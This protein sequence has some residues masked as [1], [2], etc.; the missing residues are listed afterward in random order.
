MKALNYYISAPISTDWSTVIEV[1]E[2]ISSR[3]PGSFIEKWDRNSGY[4]TALLAECD[5]MVLMLPGSGHRCWTSDIPSGC[6]AE[7]TTAK[8]KGKRIIIAVT[9]SDFGTDFFDINFEEVEDSACYDTSDPFEFDHLFEDDNWFGEQA[10]YS[11]SKSN[12]ILLMLA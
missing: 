3:D 11:S 12:K 6:K 5:I 8:R 9:D 10:E 4:D 7:I 1:E 2:A